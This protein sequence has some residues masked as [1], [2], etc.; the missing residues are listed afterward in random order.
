MISK[1]IFCVCAAC[2][3]SAAAQVWAE[4]VTL[5]VCDKPA[6]YVADVKSVEGSFRDTVKIVDYAKCTGVD[7]SLYAYDAA[8]DDWLSAGTCTIKGFNDEEKIRYSSLSKYQFLAVVPAD[9]TV[10][11]YVVKKDRSTLYF[12]V[13]D[14]E[15]DVTKD[16]LPYLKRERA[17]VFDAK[18]L[19]GSYSNY[20]KLDSKTED[21][22]IMFKVYIY[23]EHEYKWLDFGTGSLNEYGDSDTVDCDKDYDIEDYRYFAVES[24]SEKNY[25]YSVFTKHENVIMNN[26]HIQVRDMQADGTAVDELN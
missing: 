18:K 10:Y 22:D 19:D 14:T 15:T 13:Y 21:E 25:A 16:P 5:P 8:K 17:Y 26:I 12:Y 23:D 3:V 11:Q 20:I 9:G 1:K 7:F 4:D 2:I 6:S 24:A